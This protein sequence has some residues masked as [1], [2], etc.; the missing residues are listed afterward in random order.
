MRRLLICLPLCLLMAPSMP[1]RIAPAP[2]AAEP[3]PLVAKAD[4]DTTPLPTAAEMEK[5]AKDKP[6]EFLEASLKHYEKNVQGYTLTMQKQER[7]QGKLHPKEEIEVAFRDDPH[8]VLLK[9]VK[10]ARLAERSLYV[11]GENN[12]KMLVRPYGSIARFAVGDVV[13]RDPMGDDAQKSGRVFITDFGLKKGLLRTLNA[14]KAADLKG[15]LYVEHLGQKKVPEAG[16]VLCIGLRRIK[17]AKPEVDGIT[18]HTIWIDK[19]HW[20]QV[21]SIATG[22]GGKLIGEYYFR[23]IK[24]NPKFDDKQFTR[25]ALKP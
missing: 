13:S 5:L 4:R 1:D 14:W 2:P 21:G 23:D 11:E 7:L 17:F 8:S 25:E 15:E 20:L 6:V 9:W 10:G 12:G 24:L 19:E 22:E 18:E 3:R 16:D